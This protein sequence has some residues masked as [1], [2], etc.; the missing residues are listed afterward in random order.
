MKENESSVEVL[1]E[2]QLFADMIGRE[3]LLTTRSAQLNLLG[4]TFRGIFTGTVKK[5]TDGWITLDPVIIKMNNAPFH[6]F[7]TPL[8]VPIESI[9]NFVPFNSER[10]FPIP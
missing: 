10:R 2:N 9:S 5:V 8:T 3:I 6:H 7:P 1:P 4:Q